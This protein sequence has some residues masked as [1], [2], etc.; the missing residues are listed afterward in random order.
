M[1]LW[2]EQLGGDIFPIQISDEI[3]RSLK[4]ENS[5]LVN[6][7]LCRDK[8]QRLIS[9]ECCKF[10]YALSSFW[11]W[12][13]MCYAWSSHDIF[14]RFLPTFEAFCSVWCTK[15]SKKNEKHFTLTYPDTIFCPENTA[16]NVNLV[17]EKTDIVK[18]WCGIVCQSHGVEFFYCFDLK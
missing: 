16:M 4:Y 18:S 8:F 13:Q 2:H 17:D 15:M 3:M 10:H 11:I 7:Q 9:L 5:E 6:L 12:K 14:Q 1:I